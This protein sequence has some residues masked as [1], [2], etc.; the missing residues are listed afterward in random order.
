VAGTIRRE[1]VSAV[2]TSLFPIE[3]MTAAEREREDAVREGIE[4]RG[5][6]MPVEVIKDAD[7]KAIVL[8]M[9]ECTMNGTTPVPVEGTEFAIPCDIIVSAIG[10]MPELSDGLEKLDNG[11]GG[12]SVDNVYKVRGT[13]KH[14]AG[15]DIIRPHLLTTAVGHGRIAAETIDHFLA[16]HPQD[17]RPKVDAHHFN[18][19]AELQ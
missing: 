2:L 18:L 14:F 11:K 12:V 6:V 15:G 9:C 7:G 5:A 3:N 19:L 4:I 13:D 16:G 8:K 10:Q 17:R 1:G